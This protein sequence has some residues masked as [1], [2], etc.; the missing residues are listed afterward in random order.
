M[1]ALRCVLVCLACVPPQSVNQRR[2]A[3]S[4]SYLLMNTFFFSTARHTFLPPKRCNLFW[5]YAHLTAKRIEA[6]QAS[7]RKYLNIA[8][9]LFCLCV[10]LPFAQYFK[11]RSKSFTR[12]T[13]RV[14]NL[15]INCESDENWY[16]PYHYKSHTVTGVICE[17]TAHNWFSEKQPQ[18][19]YIRLNQCISLENQQIQ[20]Q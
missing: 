11:Y 12:F 5:I 18:T 20:W 15:S 1:I 14:N 8:Q 19:N 4:S 2:E 3:T 10:L 9:C 16:E 6:L 7:I 17:D 13:L